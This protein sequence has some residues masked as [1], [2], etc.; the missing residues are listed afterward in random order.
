MRFMQYFV[1]YRMRQS[2]FL[3]YMNIPIQKRKLAWHTLYKYPEHLWSFVWTPYK[4][5]PEVNVH[6]Q[7]SLLK[8][9]WLED[10]DVNVSA[11]RKLLT[12]KNKCLYHFISLLCSYT[13]QYGRKTEWHK[14]SQVIAYSQNRFVSS[15]YVTK[16]MF[17]KW[18]V[19]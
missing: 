7:K 12:F 18:L 19:Y 9:W 1:I 2:N 8:V 10:G 15:A 14:M 16:I 17:V 5:Q 13:K 11:I 4:E 6:P 3:F